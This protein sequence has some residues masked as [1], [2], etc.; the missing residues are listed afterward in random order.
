MRISLLDMSNLLYRTFYASNKQDETTI[1]LAHHKAL[2]SMNKIFRRDRPDMT[3][4]VFDRPD[5]WRKLYSIHTPDRPSPLIYKGQRRQNMTPNEAATHKRFVESVKELETLLR[6]Q[7]KITTFAADGLEADDLVAGFVQ[8][9]SGPDAHITVH[10]ADN[11][12]VQLLRYENVKVRCPIKDT[13]K[14]LEDYNDDPDWFMFVKCCKGDQSDNVLRIFPK[15]YM[16]KVKTYY[17]DEL[18]R[19]NAFNDTWLFKDHTVHSGKL[20][21][22]NKLL[23]DLRHQPQGIRELIDE[24]IDIELARPKRFK[25]QEFWRFC[26]AHDLRKIADDSNNFMGLLNTHPSA[27]TWSRPAG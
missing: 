26:A 3:V 4:A 2:M 12:Y 18:A 15:V 6:E 14:T 1:S 21:E 16:A 8:R 9:Y 22:E 20:F 25:M 5:N 13:Y 24:T 27:T 17:T 23:M 7:T 10:S 11:D 19:V